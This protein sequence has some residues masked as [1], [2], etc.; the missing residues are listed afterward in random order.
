MI[1]K[2]PDQFFQQAKATDAAADRQPYRLG[3]RGFVGSALA[4][5]ALPIGRAWADANNVE[6][7]EQLAAIGLDGKPFVIARAD[8]NQF[9]ESLHG[10]LLLAGNEGY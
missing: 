9:R 7:P 10:Q 1:I 3:R 5:A 4:A 6:L 8:I 2:I